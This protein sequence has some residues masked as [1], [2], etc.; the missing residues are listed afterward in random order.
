MEGLSFLLNYI[1]DWLYFGTDDE[2]TKEFEKL[3]KE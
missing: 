3:L 1:D 2:E